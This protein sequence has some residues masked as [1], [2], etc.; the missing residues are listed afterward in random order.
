MK[1]TMILLAFLF[2]GC[3]TVLTPPSWV[4]GDSIKYKNSQY[5]IGRGQA[6][7]VSDAADRARADLAK[8][9]QVAIAAKSEDVQRFKS[10]EGSGNYSDESSRRITTHTN[11]IISGIQ[12]AEIWQDPVDKTQ[13][14]LAILPRMKAVASLREQIG[15]LDDATKA[16]IDQSRQN[17]DLF[18]KIGFASKAVELQLEREGLQK[19]LQ[20]VD[21][22]GRGVDVQYNTGQLTADMNAL[23]Q[24][25]K[26][27]PIAAEGAMAGL[28]TAVASALSEA[29]F[30][31][32]NS[33]KAGY[34]LR[35][36]L[37]LTDL[38]EKEGFDWQRGELEITLID[39]QGQVRGT[40]SWFVKGV[41]TDAGTAMQ[42]ALDA[43]TEKL[44]KNMRSTIVE[45][46]GAQ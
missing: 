24:T 15:Q 19:D 3:T 7:T 42:R 25:I 33:D 26:I 18:R 32:D 46:A 17:A 36:S 13:H 40:K 27:R 31:V 9:F 44:N 5:L 38:G 16:D 29:G 8:T 10:G 1:S 21:I 30:M 43:A 2:A 4:N 23:L 28:N 34:T 22:T 14:A 39:S 20:V 11:Q 41:A 37:N 35:S 6:S 45:M 12:I